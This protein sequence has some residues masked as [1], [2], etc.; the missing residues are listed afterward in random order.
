MTEQSPWAWLSDLLARRGRL[1]PCR[2]ASFR[3]SAVASSPRPRRA[4]RWR[5][6]LLTSAL[7]LVSAPAVGESFVLECS[8]ETVNRNGDSLG[9]D[10]FT[11]HIDTN[12]STVD[13]D[14][15]QIDARTIRFSDPY[16]KG[17]TTVID[18]R[19]G[20]LKGSNGTQTSTGSCKRV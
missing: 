20:Q 13:G 2:R 17:A 3:H 4:I 18:L 12:R 10:S 9:R 11:L 8:L 16:V 6:A 5:K 14:P 19:S 7:A 1:L 15:A